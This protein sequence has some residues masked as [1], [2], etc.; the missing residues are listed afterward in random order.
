[1]FVSFTLGIDTKSKQNNFWLIWSEHQSR[2]RN[3]CFRWLNG[4]HATVEDA[5]SQVRDKAHHHFTHSTEVIRSPFSWLCK[6]TYNICIDIQ[7][8]QKKYHLFCEVVNYCPEQFSFSTYITDSLEGEIQHQQELE[9]L[10]QALDSLSHDLKQVIYYRF[11]N[12]MEYF[13]IAECMRITP[14]NVRKRVQLARK[15]LK[16]LIF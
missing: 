12:E 9:N 14:A 2:L 16:E 3:C 1:M 11:I 15:K 5:L 7:R 13:E 6:I 8:D 4:N 10:F